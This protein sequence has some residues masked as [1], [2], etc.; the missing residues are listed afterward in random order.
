LSS[1]KNAVESGERD[2]VGALKWG[3]WVERPFIISHK[4]QEYLRLYPASL[5]NMRTTTEFFID[6]RPATADEVKPYVLASEFRERDEDLKCFT[7]K[8]ANLVH[9]GE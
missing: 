3:Q 8:V 9:I 7:I 1:V 6:E 2:E 5:N 4:D